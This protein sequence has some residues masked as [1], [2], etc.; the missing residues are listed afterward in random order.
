[1]IQFL[2]LD[3]EGVSNYAK[4]Q[5]ALMKAYPEGKKGEKIGKKLLKSKNFS[6]GKNMIGVGVSGV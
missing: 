2:T 5:L 4:I 6:K 3:S 1:M